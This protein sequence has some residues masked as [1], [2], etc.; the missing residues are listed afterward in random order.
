VVNGTGDRMRLRNFSQ[1]RE[2]LEKISSAQV[3]KAGESNL[4]SEKYFQN[5][6]YKKSLLWMLKLNAYLIKR[7]ADFYYFTWKN[8]PSLMLS[9]FCGR[10]IR[11]K[12]SVSLSD[13]SPKL[14]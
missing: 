4:T 11:I 8:Y 10:G 7:S 5:H 3:L 2:G 1:D 13:C 6:K 12:P 9:A 14:C